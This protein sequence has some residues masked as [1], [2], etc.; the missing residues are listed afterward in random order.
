MALSLRDGLLASIAVYVAWGYATDYLPIL[1]YLLFAFLSG[2]LVTVVVFVAL[3]LY[4]SQRPHQF[5]RDS[6]DQKATV[7]FLRPQSWD[8]ETAQFR[9]DRDYNPEKLYPQSFVVSDAIDGLISLALRDFVSSWYKNISKDPTFINEIEKGIRGAAGEIRDRLFKEDIV[10]IGVSRIV[11]IITQ[12]MRDF[13]TAER[14]VRGKA[15]NRNVTE[16][17]EL[18][19]AIAAKYRDGKLHPAA[20]LSFSDTKLAQQDHVRKMLILVLPEVLPEALVK[21][22]AVS[23][24]IKEIVACAVLFPVLQML[25]DPDFWNQL[26]EGYGRPALQDRKTVRKL[27]AALDEHAS[28]ALASKQAETLPRLKA[29]D[30]ERAF[31]RFVRAIRRCNNISDARRFRSQIASQLKRENM[32]EE[33]DQTYIRRLETGKRVLDQKVAKLATRGGTTQP[34]R[35]VPE[36]RGSYSNASEASLVGVMHHSSGLSYFMEYMDRQNKTVL[37][38][39]WV[40]VDGFRNPLEDDFGDEAES[41]SFAWTETDRN[42]VAAINETYLS[43]PELKVPEESRKAVKAFL[44]AGEQATPAQYRQARTAI[45]SAQSATLEEMQ[46]QHFPAFK[47]SDLY[48]KYLTS[49][50]VSTPGFNTLPT[51]LDAPIMSKPLPLPPLRT[52]SKPVQKSRDLR[53]AAASATDVRASTKLFEDDSRR[54]F[55]TDRSAPLFDDDDDTDPLASSTFSLGSESQNGET[56]NQKQ[57]IENM[58]AALNTIIS[59][60][61]KDETLE[62]TRDSLFGPPPLSIPSGKTSDSPR[63]SL[64]LPHIES[65]AGEKLRPSIASLGLVNKAG[66]IGVFTDND[67]FED[68]EKFIEDEYADSGKE[69]EGDPAEEI[70]EAEPGDL[71]LA[72]VIATLN[73]DI[74]KLISQEAVVDTLTRKAELTN[75]LVELRILGPSK[76]SLQREIRRKE[77]QRQQYIVQESDNSLYGRAT[78]RIKSVM[79]YKEDDGKDFAKCKYRLE[80]TG[81]N[82]LLT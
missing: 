60:D 21:S 41:S 68:Q 32:V 78:V 44:A 50:E 64:D 54:S 28:P 59:E 42:D 65:L 12:H 47:K 1:R 13:E 6:R 80:S 43:K 17:E 39:F 75:N 20:S 73:A 51:E 45:L 26:I 8:T 36:Q 67:L 74:E 2:I 62:D 33:Q 14:I 30:T 40:V 46:N 72:E 77:L 27:R 9:H 37:V 15:L 31:E 7:A 10:T 76:Y 81:S 79:V 53:R 56:G 22:R 38:Q 11:P 25:M 52:S 82:L 24:L 16:S 23:I 5:D 71:G 66:R 61:P 48:Y 55:D 19:M 3:T 29:N 63:A 34:S 4:T 49:D 58:E 35:P 57:M 18:D 70:H 69:S